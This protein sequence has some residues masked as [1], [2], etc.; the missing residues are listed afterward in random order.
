MDNAQIE[1]ELEDIEA[2]LERLRAL[3][4]QYFLGMEKLEPAVL[5]KEVD[6]KFWV[7]RREQIRNTGLR[8]KFQMLIQR[9]NTYQQ[10]WTRVVREIENGTY[11]RDVI[12]VAQRFGEKE[13]ITMVGKRRAAQYKR[14]A[15]NQIERKNR[16]KGAA[17][18]EDGD[19]TT[20][21]EVP[22]D[23]DKT[24][25][26]A[27]AQAWP[28]D[29]DAVSLDADD[30][31]LIEDDDDSGAPTIRREL[32][33]AKPRS[34]PDMEHLLQLATVGS[35]TRRD[36]PAPARA[37][38]AIA[39]GILD[40]P[41]QEISM[42]DAPPTVRDAPP[43]LRVATPD[44]LK[45]PPPV[46]VPVKARAAPAAASKNRV[47]ELA[48]QMRAKKQQADK[49]KAE[50]LDLDLFEGD[51]A[52]RRPAPAAKEKPSPAAKEKPSPAAKERPPVE[53]K[54]ASIAKEKPAPAAA[55][56]A[57]ADAAPSPKPAPANAP[58]GE[59]LS[60]Q[61]MRD[62]YAKYVGAKRA[63]NESTA[64]ITY[65]KLAASLRA[66]ADKLRTA[67]PSRSIDFEIVTKDG[68]TALRPVVK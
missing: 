67:H 44:A 5:R 2:K 21:V 36:T 49:P 61:K 28:P 23:G 48:A 32:P 14:L 45:L 38:P 68:K 4:E 13:A 8:F 7:L 63:A 42:R 43:T 54:P 59:G 53:Q 15:A 30:L 22:I 25:E 40:E 33:A 62:I 29:D 9:Y 55:R 52:S 26:V 20:T 66:Q 60:E 31:E 19:A 18:Q 39:P 46:F 57:S 24:A 6:R 17:A 34:E 64:G 58:G 37:A 41:T 56:P 47:A 1:K 11:R 35:A 3:Y 27:I 65:D 50:A 16:R 51:A 10:Y 12:K